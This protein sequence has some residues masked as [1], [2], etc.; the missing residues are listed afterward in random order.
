MVLYIKAAFPQNSNLKFSHFSVSI[1]C[2]SFEM[3]KGNFYNSLEY[4]K[5]SPSSLGFLLLNC[6]IWLERKLNDTVSKH[7]YFTLKF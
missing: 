4:E 3:K 7:G 6:V 2:Q 1:F 5:M